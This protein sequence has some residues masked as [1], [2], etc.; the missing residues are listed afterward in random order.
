MDGKLLRRGN[1]QGK[2]D[3]DLTNQKILVNDRPG[4]QASSGGIVD[5][6]EYAQI[7]R[8]RDPCYTDTARL[9]AKIGC[10]RKLHTGA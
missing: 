7:S 8:T 5:D 4:T 1:I 2:G 3:S 6:E 10:Y 9:S